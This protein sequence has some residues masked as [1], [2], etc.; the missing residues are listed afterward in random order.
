ML[1]PYTIIA[2]ALIMF[3]SF[4]ALTIFGSLDTMTSAYINYKERMAKLSKCSKCSCKDS[5]ENPED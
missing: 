5:V 3:G 1:D 4:L 2:L